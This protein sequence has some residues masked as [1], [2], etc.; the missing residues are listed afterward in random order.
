MHQ[1]ARAND[2][3][4]GAGR[5]AQ[6]A[7]DAGGF[8]NESDGWCGSQAVCCALWNDGDVE[9]CSQFGNDFVATGRALVDRCLACSNGIGIRPAARMVALAALGLRQQGINVIRTGHLV[10][11]QGAAQALMQSPISAGPAYTSPL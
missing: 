1:F 4:D 9:Q 10:P 11:A 6:G 7:A 3:I 5:Q 8:I 2:G